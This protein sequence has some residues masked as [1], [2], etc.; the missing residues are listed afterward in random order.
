MGVA[1]CFL[2]FINSEDYIQTSEKYSLSYKGAYV[3]D[4]KNI[5][6]N[7]SRTPESSA[8]IVRLVGIL[9]TLDLFEG[10]NSCS[11]QLSFA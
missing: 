11:E 2:R 10:K 4:R 3:L 9:H 8:V 5:F 6:C 1:K 7:E